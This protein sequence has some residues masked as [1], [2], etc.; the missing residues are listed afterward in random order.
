[1]YHGKLDLG[2]A[3]GATFLAICPFMRKL[4][5]IPEHARP[6]LRSA[7]NVEGR[8]VYLNPQLAWHG[9]VADA[10]DGRGLNKRF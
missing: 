4:S 9:M 10:C 2:Y 1:M 3:R 6:A 5:C 8:P 7:C